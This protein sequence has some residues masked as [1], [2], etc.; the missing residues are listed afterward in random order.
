MRYQ[1]INLKNLI[2]DQNYQ[3]SVTEGNGNINMQGWD[4]VATGAND[5]SVMLSGDGLQKVQV[6]IQAPNSVPPE[7]LFLFQ[8]NTFDGDTTITDTMGNMGALLDNNMAHS[9]DVAKFGTSSFKCDGSS[10]FCLDND[11]RIPIGTGDGTLDLW[12]YRIGNMPQYGGLCC[13]IFSNATGL[14]LWLD[15]NIAGAGVLSSTHSSYGVGLPIPLNEW[16][17][18]AVTRHNGNI[19]G[20][21]NGQLQGTNYDA[22]AATEQKLCVGRRYAFSNSQYVS[23]NCYI[24]EIRY[25][26]GLAVWQGENFTPPTEPYTI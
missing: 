18:L 5:H 15:Y 13:P 12:V 10:S 8:S 9:T 22:S 4:G 24:D 19:Y 25:I 11:P 7:T 26:P 6:A 23:S 2:T 17:H 14:A 20:Y 16:T 21:I 3:V 1:K